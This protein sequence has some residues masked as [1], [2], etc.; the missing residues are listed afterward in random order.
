[1][2][3]PS[4]GGFGAYARRRCFFDFMA[5]VVFIVSPADLLVVRPEQIA[6]VTVLVTSRLSLVVVSFFGVILRLVLRV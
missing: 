4:S 1:M 2:P 5:F 6:A 3:I